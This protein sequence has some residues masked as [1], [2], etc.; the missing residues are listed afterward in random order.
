MIQQ[1]VV[2]KSNKYGIT[3]CLDKDIAFR[4]L[5][6]QIAEKYLPNSLVMLRWH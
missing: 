5:L 6:S 3:L 1:T 2:I 4:D